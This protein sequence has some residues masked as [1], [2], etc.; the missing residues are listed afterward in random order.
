M[1]LLT[2]FFLVP[3][4]ETNIAWIPLLSLDEA[5]MEN[6]LLVRDPFFGVVRVI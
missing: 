2:L 6:F 5:L 4:M 1:V 3:L